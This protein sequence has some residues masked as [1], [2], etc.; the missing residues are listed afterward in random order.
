MAPRSGL[1]AS[2]G[3]Y[4]PSTGEIF[5]LSWPM[6]LRAVMTF[7]IVI[8]D[9][10]LVSSL[11]EEAVTS[12]GVAGVII[13]LVMGTNLAFANAMQIRV[14]QAFGSANALHLK[15]AFYC[16]LAINLTL[17]LAG[18]LLILL[19]GSSLVGH[20]AHSSGVAKG[21]T[22][23]LNIFALV[24]LAEAISAA[25]SSYFNGCGRTRVSLYSFALSA[26]INIVASIVLIFGTSD[27]QGLG[28]VG[29][30]WGSFIG[31]TFRL[32]YL[33]SMFRRRNSKL[34]GIPGWAHGSMLAST[35]RQ[36]AFSWPIAA[37]FVS[38]TFANQACA[39]IHVNLNM[40]QF[41]A[42][43]L[44]A[45]WVVLAG[46][47][48]ITWTQATGILIA[49]M[50][51]NLSKPSALDEFL[52]RAW[53]GAFIASAV[54]AL[55]YAVI[56]LATRWIYADLDSETRVT[57]L[58][59]LPVLMLL[60]FPRTSNAI[61][62]NALRAAGDTKTSMNI[63]MAGNWLFMV[64]M[65]AVFVLILDLSAAWVFALVLMEE[66]VKLP[67]FHRRIWGGEWHLR[68]S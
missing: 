68:R 31:A 9:L 41:A 24:L 49:Q 12:I 43:T 2:A 20:L 50:I 27:L 8:I 36:F 14:A 46:Q 66:F 59:F 57:L 64:P 60:P 63:H 48:S 45:P 4:T 58:S 1:P 10:Y 33:V 53:R 51:G 3:V 18:V 54:V 13:G 17:V 21:A 61:C 37:T 15:T 25:L 7:S 29:A 62:G 5:A 67:F 38:L 34:V 11:G 35:Q 6:A 56:I 44:I 16:G 26:P 52:S 42:M 65:T 32:V 23:Y 28:L 19:F 30:A 47:I 40:N 39:A 22:A 55:A